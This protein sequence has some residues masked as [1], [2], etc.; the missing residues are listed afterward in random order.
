MS[1]IHVGVKAPFPYTNR[2][3][4]QKRIHFKNEGA[5]YSY[6]TSTRDSVKPVQSIN[7]REL[8][9]RGEMIIGHQV[10]R[11]VDGNWRLFI[12]A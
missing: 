7:G 4:I 8:Y 11:K 6:F 12:A 3:F 1:V 10:L 5:F 2:D 9:V